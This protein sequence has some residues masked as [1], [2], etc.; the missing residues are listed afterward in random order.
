MLHLKIQVGSKAYRDFS[1]AFSLCRWRVE[2]QRSYMTCLRSLI[3]VGIIVFHYLVQVSSRSLGLSRSLEIVQHLETSLLESE[4]NQESMLRPGPQ[5][6]PSTSQ[7]VRP[8]PDGS[9]LRACR[10]RAH[11]HLE[12]APK[13]DHNPLWKHP[14]RDFP[15][16][17][18]CS[19]HSAVC[20]VEW[21]SEKQ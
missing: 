4:L 16:P 20:G 19:Q 15:F 14:L 21:D 7:S 2:D 6:F 12:M 1:S 3:I 17:V 13:G 10:A 5:G 18:K 11:P 9:C 8:L